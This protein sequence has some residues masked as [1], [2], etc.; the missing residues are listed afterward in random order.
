MN[1][2]LSQAITILFTLASS[3]FAAGE[4]GGFIEYLK[5]V[6][7]YRATPYRCAGGYWTIG[8]GHQ[9]KRGEVFVYL[10]KEDAERLLQADLGE[11]YKRIDAKYGRLG[12]WKRNLLADYYFNLGSM[13]GFPKMEIA[14]LG[15]DLAAMRKE[16]K[17]Y[18]NGRELGRNKHFYNHF[19]K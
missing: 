8:Y 15:G 9:I 14:I 16:Y 7:G 13:R 11:V 17:R 18:V 3:L 6:E 19:L 4:G 10:P 12:D 1:K 2:I 5:R